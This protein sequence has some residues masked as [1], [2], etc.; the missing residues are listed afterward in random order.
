MAGL[1]GAIDEGVAA[2]GLVHGLEDLLR[3]AAEHVALDVIGELLAETGRPGV[4]RGQQHVTRRREEVDV[5]PHR[6]GVARHAVGSAM[7]VH[8]QRIRP[9]AV[10]PRRK[11]DHAVN[12]LAVP[13]GELEMLRGRQVQLREPLAVE[14]GEQG[15]RLAARIHAGDLGRLRAGPSM[16]RR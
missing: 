11:E 4:V 3:R 10:E 15:V 7:G 6:E 13:G 5:P 16:G 8:D 14:R 12:P 1:A 2:T 9:R